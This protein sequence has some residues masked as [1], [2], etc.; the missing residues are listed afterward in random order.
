M[1]ES[2]VE[3]NEADGVGG[4]ID[5]MGGRGGWCRGVV[6]LGRCRDQKD[7][8]AWWWEEERCRWCGPG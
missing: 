5:W 2:A 1:N 6:R 3:V 7:E 8:E 4:W